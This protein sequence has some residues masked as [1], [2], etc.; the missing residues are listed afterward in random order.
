MS[1]LSILNSSR[2][3]S[4]A[5]LLESCTP[6]QTTASVTTSPETNVQTSSKCS[7][8]PQDSCATGESCG[9]PSARNCVP[10]LDGAH[11][12]KNFYLNGIMTPLKNARTQVEQLESTIGENVNLL[13]NPTQNLISDTAEA[14]ANLSGIDTQVS[15]EARGHFRE[16]LEQGQPVRI[17]AHSQGAAIAADALRELAHE[18]HQE[19]L[20]SSQIKQRMSQVEVISFGGFATQ[21]SFPE[22]VRT[23]LINK[24]H[25]YVPRIANAFYAVGEA[26]RSKEADFLPALGNAAKVVGSGILFNFGQACG[27]AISQGFRIATGQDHAY[28]GMTLEEGL[29]R[30]MASVCTEVES[31]HLA[32]V[33]NDYVAKNVNQGYLTDFAEEYT[34]ETQASKVS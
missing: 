19:G 4:P 30:Y 11:P 14:L 20:S 7:L 8:K 1:N 6:C 32:L 10:F 25:D 29:S 16:A 21:K 23:R 26:T 24:G 22:G 31:D 18:Y 28:H 5:H 17:F 13:Y 3:L 34:R 2:T 12:P 9:T 33:S 27:A 15:R